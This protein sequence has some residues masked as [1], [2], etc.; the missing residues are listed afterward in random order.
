[1]AARDDRITPKSSYIAT[2]T[3]SCAIVSPPKGV[4]NKLRRFWS[5]S[6]RAVSTNT[7]SMRNLTNWKKVRTRTK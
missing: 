7:A 2:L 1:M 3:T 5:G 4:P 6:N